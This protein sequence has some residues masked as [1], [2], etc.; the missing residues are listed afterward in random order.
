MQKAASGLLG[1]VA[2]ELVTCST[3]SHVMR[4]AASGGCGLKAGHVVVQMKRLL[5][6]ELATG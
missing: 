5:A 2:S 3:H 6:S 4:E 1:A